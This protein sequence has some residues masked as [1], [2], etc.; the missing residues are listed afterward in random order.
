[1]LCLA[2]SIDGAATLSK[3]PH[4]A[5][6]ATIIHSLRD[7]D[8]YLSRVQHNMILFQREHGC[9]ALVRIGVTGGGIA[10]HYRIQPDKPFWD[11][12]E[13]SI[14]G[15]KKD[16]LTRYYKAYNGRSHEHFAGWGAAVKVMK[17]ATGEE[18]EDYGADDGKDKAAQSLGR[19]GG[20]ARAAAL[21]KKRRSEIA[22]AAAAK[23]WRKA[24]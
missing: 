2:Q 13:G 17:I 19:R 23:R 3:L 11:A 21:S 5:T 7:P 16:D 22:K 20:K 6:V 4:D 18:P 1:M 14:F 24:P 12:L 15:G 8:K 10:P 9:V